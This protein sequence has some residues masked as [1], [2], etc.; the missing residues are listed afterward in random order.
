MS[1]SITTIQ[2]LAAHWATFFTTTTRE[3]KVDLVTRNQDAPEELATACYD[4]HGDFGPDDWRYVFILH[5][6]RAIED[7]DED[8]DGDDLRDLC[9]ESFDGSAYLIYTGYRLEWLASNLQRPSYVDDAT[10][11]YGH[12][13]CVTSIGYG[14]MSEYEE[15]AASIIDSL[16]NALNAIEEDEDED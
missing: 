8:S 6:L 11:E 15:V 3:G 14:M 13:D 7:A 2:Q 16:G 4:A 5:A 9:R 1:K 10:D 12:A